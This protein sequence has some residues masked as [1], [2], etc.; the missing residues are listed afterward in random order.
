MKEKKRNQFKKIR[1]LETVN[2]PVMIIT[3]SYN[4]WPLTYMK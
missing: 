4:K 2:Q 1:N 3:L